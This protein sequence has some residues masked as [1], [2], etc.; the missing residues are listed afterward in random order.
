MSLATVAAGQII[1]ADDHNSLL[2]LFV[3]KTLDETLNNNAT[4][5]NDDE[6]FLSVVANIKYWLSMR[7]IMSSGA[8]PDFKMLFTFPTGLT[9][10]LHNVEATGALSVP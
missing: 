10:K 8:T 6:L 4:L 5:Q 9:M 2:P 7:L 1:L 3:V